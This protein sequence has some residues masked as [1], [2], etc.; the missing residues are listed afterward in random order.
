MK[1]AALI[2]LLTLG[3][4]SLAN[5]AYV[6]LTLT[7]SAPDWAGIGPFTV[8]VVLSGLTGSEQVSMLKDGAITI[9]GLSSYTPGT[10]TANSKFDGFN[11]LTFSELQLNASAPGP[12][13][14]NGDTVFSFTVAGTSAGY[15]DFGMD[16]LDAGTGKLLTLAT[17][18]GNYS[19]YGYP[20]LGPLTVIGAR[21]NFGVIPEPA[22]LLLLGLGALILRKRRRS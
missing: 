4:A 14:G 15:L 6:P 12:Y 21:T 7:F 18:L 8:N 17:D 16:H 19:Y 22:T 20:T 5:A 11:T 2:I 3:M 9:G 13:V 10:I 1:R